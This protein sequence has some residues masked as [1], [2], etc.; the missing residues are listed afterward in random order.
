MPRLTPSSVT[1]VSV[2]RLRALNFS[3]NTANPTWDF[4]DVGIWSTVEINV[5][6]ICVCMPSLRLLLVRVFPRLSPSA[7]R[8][9]VHGDGKPGA[10]G[11]AAAR[12]QP[13]QTGTTSRVERSHPGPPVNPNQISYQTSYEIEYGDKDLDELQLVIM[14]DPD[15]KTME[16]A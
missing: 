15:G 9:Y 14:R 10:Y 11:R 7:H 8:Y 16:S 6:I 1:I 5:G 12:Q 3:A 13:R 2:L 4:F